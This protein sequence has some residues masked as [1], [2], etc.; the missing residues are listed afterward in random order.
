[1]PGRRTRL[2]ELFDAVERHEKRL[3]FLISGGTEAGVLTSDYCHR[4]VL[5]LA[6]VTA[7][8]RPF[9]VNGINY[10]VMSQKAG[11]TQC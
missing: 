9:N 2:V 3:L 11:V 8:L 4:V 5:R 10:S 1:M 7:L 6:W